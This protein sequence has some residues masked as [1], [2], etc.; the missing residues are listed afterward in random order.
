MYLILSK[1]AYW[2]EK[3]NISTDGGGVWIALE[4]TTNVNVGN[5]QGLTVKPILFFYTVSLNPRFHLYVN[6]SAIYMGIQ[7]C[8]TSHNLYIQ[9]PV[10]WLP[11]LLGDFSH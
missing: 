4:A 9:P 7:T 3:L 2:K 10:E 11:M 5:P 6:N 1:C 8:L